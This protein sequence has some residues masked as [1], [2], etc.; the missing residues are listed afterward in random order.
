MIV[1]FNQDKMP[2]DVSEDKME[3]IESKDFYQLLEV[4]PL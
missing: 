4:N 1:F 3:D 2:E